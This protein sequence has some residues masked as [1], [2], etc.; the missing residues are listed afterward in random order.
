MKTQELT[1]YVDMD[2]VLSNF[3]KT[4]TSMWNNFKYDRILFRLS[5]V[6][7]RIF[8]KLEKMPSADILLS[9][10]RQLE[11]MY[12]LN[13]EILTSTGSHRT[14]MKLAGMEQKR[15]WLD[16]HGINW[17]ANFVCSKPEKA[18]YASPTTILLDDMA[19]CIDPFK[20]KGG[21][22]FLYKDDENSEV[23]QGLKWYLQEYSNEYV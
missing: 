7:H 5:V 22:G 17:K 10:L 4:Y 3:E 9:E 16:K 15:E 21:M 12:G 11:S 19:G 1:L 23:I 2:G 6:E 20:E 14:E 13:I 8:A 18:Q